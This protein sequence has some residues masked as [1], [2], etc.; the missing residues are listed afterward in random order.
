VPDKLKSEVAVGP[1]GAENQTRMSV[2]LAKWNVLFRGSVGVS[3]GDGKC[4]V[5][6]GDGGGRAL[7]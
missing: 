2:G 6:F 5:K 4:V 3:M 1:V 7:P